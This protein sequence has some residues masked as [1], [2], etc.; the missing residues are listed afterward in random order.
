MTQNQSFVWAQPSRSL[1]ICGFSDAGED[2]KEKRGKKMDKVLHSLDTF[3]LPAQ[4]LFPSE[5][6]V[7]GCIGPINQRVNASTRKHV[8]LSRLR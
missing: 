6:K 2:K 4:V 7:N 5:P 1:S 8:G 3:L